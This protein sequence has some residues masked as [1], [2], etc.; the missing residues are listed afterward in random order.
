MLEDGTLLWLAIKAI[1]IAALPLA[2]VALSRDPHKLRKLTWVTAFLTFD[3]IAFGAFTRLTDSGLGCPDWPGC[4]GHSNPLS[5][6]E[7][8][9]A[10]ET[11][12]P[13]G[14]VTMTK[15]WIEM[16]HRYF[17]M[18]VG[19]LIIVLMVMHWRR[20]LRS[21]APAHAPWLAT[22]TL[23][24]VC[25]QG[26]FGAWT[27]T[28]KLQ[29]AIVTAHLLG[30]LA[31]LA[32][33]TWQALRE[34][35]AASVAPTAARLRPLA[36][37]AF[38]LL[39]VQIALG[40]WV[41]TNYAVLACPDFPLCHG[42]LVPDMDFRHGFALWRDL[43]MTVGGEPIPF[44]ALV[45]VHWVHRMFAFVV[46]AVLGLLAWRAWRQPGLRRLARLLAALT[47]LQFTTGLS[48]VVLSWPLLLAVLHSAGA[49]ALVAVMVAFS[50][51][52]ALAPAG[53][54]VV[55]AVGQA[56]PAR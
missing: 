17:A 48:N 47:L 1:A 6:G 37:A 41:S 16:V 42:R 26:A 11:A 46:I 10:A 45:A 5:A 38:A 28:M 52:L 27:V 32:L 13:S 56:T 44:Q 14:P 50:Y 49:A 4:Y 19:F 18:A 40:G 51:R 30:G 25:L 35:T 53:E 23:F 22:F 31:L 36:L 12:L 55:G 3:L 20:W 34:A 33:L 9:R 21:R 43:G 2:Y 15:A 54:V 8:I 39:V 24:A 7:Q 29:P